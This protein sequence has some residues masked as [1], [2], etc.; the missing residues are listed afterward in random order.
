MKV[1]LFVLALVATTS[2]A[3]AADKAPEFKAV[4]P[5]EVAGTYE[6][7][8][9]FLTPLASRFEETGGVVNNGRA[10]ALRLL[11]EAGKQNT[12]VMNVAPDGKTTIKAKDGKVDCETTKVSDP[13]RSA[14]GGI[15]V[16]VDFKCKVGLA[17]P[18]KGK[19]SL[20]TV[21]ITLTHDQ[22]LALKSGKTTDVPMHVAK[23]DGVTGSTT[24]V[25]VTMN[26]FHRTE[27]TQME[28]RDEGGTPGDSKGG[29]A[30][31]N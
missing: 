4:G 20:H 17:N 16:T 12:F 8:M 24:D 6:Y 22:L 1:S 7:T 30:P 13:V 27:K 31:A 18:F 3:S 19:V 11:P 5:K 26:G 29:T 10:K 28:G 23:Y 25:K 9:D 21:T 14:D 2:S 15:T